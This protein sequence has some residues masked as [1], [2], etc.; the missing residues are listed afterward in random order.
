MEYFMIDSN[1]RGE[2]FEIFQL[3]GISACSVLQSF[4]G[5]YLGVLR[6]YND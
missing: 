5:V 6:S 3:C 2:I 1:L 4:H